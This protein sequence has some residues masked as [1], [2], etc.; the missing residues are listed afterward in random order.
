LLEV[1]D[2]GPPIADCERV[3]ERMWR[4]DAARSATGLHAGIG[5]SLARSL[6]AVLGLTLT[7]RNEDRI[8]RFVV[9]SARS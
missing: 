2:S 4:G 6:A 5:L 3:F 9:S 8:V 7:C 1:A